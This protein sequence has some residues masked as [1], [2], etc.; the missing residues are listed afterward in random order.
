M[1]LFGSE[2]LISTRSDS[3]NYHDRPMSERIQK[4][5]DALKG[6]CQKHDIKQA[7]LARMLGIRRQQLNDYLSRRK[8]PSGDKVL[9]MQEL[10]RKNPRRQGKGKDSASEP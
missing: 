2:A 4:L 10:L 6:Y 7:D 9:L 1:H 3:K 5:L 8:Q